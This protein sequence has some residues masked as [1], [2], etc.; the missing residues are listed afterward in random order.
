MGLP[1]GMIKGWFDRYMTSSWA[2]SFNPGG[3]QRSYKRTGRLRRLVRPLTLLYT[4]DRKGISSFMYTSVMSYPLMYQV[5]AGSSPSYHLEADLFLGN[6]PLKYFDGPLWWFSFGRYFVTKKNCGAFF[7]RIRVFAN[8]FDWKNNEW[9]ARTATIMT[10]CSPRKHNL[11][12]QRK[13]NQ[14]WWNPTKPCGYMDLRTWKALW[15]T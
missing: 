13:L 14:F 2:W 6:K 5:N 9:G 12:S 11:K 7:R 1:R 15:L 4:L 3:T 8:A 10:R